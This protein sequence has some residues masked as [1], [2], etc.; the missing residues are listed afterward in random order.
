MP[1]GIAGPNVD[2]LAP[3]GSAKSTVLG[4]FTAGHWNSHSS[5]GRRYR[6]SICLTRLILH[7]PSLQPSSG[8]LRVS[9][10]KRYSQGAAQQARHL[11]RAFRSIDHARQVEITGE[12]AFTLC[13]AGLKGSVT[14]TFA[15]G[16]DRYL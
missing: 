9:G 5:W 10:S 13:A 3:R 8:S 11:K 4:L 6:S 14:Q 1:D 2:L 12:E 7:D 16:H 15:A